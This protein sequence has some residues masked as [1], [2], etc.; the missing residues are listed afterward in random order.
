MH[1]RSPILHDVCLLRQYKYP[2]KWVSKFFNS[3]FAS[4]F[5]YMLSTESIKKFFSLS[6]ANDFIPKAVTQPRT[7]AV[8]LPEFVLVADVC[9]LHLDGLLTINPDPT[10][11]RQHHFGHSIFASLINFAPLYD[12]RA[13]S[14]TVNHRP[15][16]S[17]SQCLKTVPKF[18]QKTI[19]LISAH[20][21][22]TEEALLGSPG[23][24]NDILHALCGSPTALSH[25]F[26]CLAFYRTPVACKSSPSFSC[27][28]P[29]IDL[30]W[31]SALD[32]DFFCPRTFCT[33]CI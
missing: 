15:A 24:N 17:L 9:F 33:L 14:I 32:P 26:P 1:T 16:A 20:L 29:Q 21:G 23:T 5:G 25:P 28:T 8:C 2:E 19:F 22:A 10:H 27:L 7:F 13:C 11:I 4:I 3:S 31:L 18:T 12:A 6:P 30:L